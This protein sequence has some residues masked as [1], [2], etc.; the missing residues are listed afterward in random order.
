MSIRIA[1]Q[2][3]GK[4]REI[5]RVHE[6]SVTI[7]EDSPLS[8]LMEKLA[9][10]HGEAFSLKGIQRNSYVVLINGRHYETLDAERTVLKDGDI[11][12]FMPVTMGG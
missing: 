1:S 10:A 4:L 6:E 7:S 5:A 11:V 8:R 9:E 3:L 2:Y 12:I